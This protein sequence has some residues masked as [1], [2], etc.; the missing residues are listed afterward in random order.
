[1]AAAGVPVLPELDPA[2]VTD[3]DL[4]VLVKASAGGGG[5]GMRIV[6]TPGRAARG[7]RDGASAE[8]AS[9]FGDPTVFCEPYVEAGRH[10]EVQVLAD[11][12]GT[13]WSLGERECSLQ[14]RHQKVVEETPSPMVDDALRAELSAAAVAAAKAIDYVGAG[15]VEFLARSPEHDGRRPS[16]SSRRTPACRSSTRSPSASP[17]STWS[18]SSCGSRRGSGCADAAAGAARRSDR[19]PALRGGPGRRTGA[20]PAARCAASPSPGCGAS[21]TCST[22]PASGWTPGSSTARPSARPTT[23]CWPR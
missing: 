14:R 23:R 18:P 16:G 12:H 8:A 21:S 10:I 1:M 13:V 7:D 5:R 6:R 15:T 19:G 20:R 17:G 4:P 2:A 3:A 11:T 22:G 9:A